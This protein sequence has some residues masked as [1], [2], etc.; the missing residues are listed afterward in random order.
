MIGRGYIRHSTWQD[1]IAQT[2]SWVL[3]YIYCPVFL[4]F[5]NFLVLYAE[6]I[7]KNFP[8]TMAG[9]LHKYTKP[10]DFQ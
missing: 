6:A 8:L 9:D 10:V 7:A 5:G 2:V 3:V 1:V 4:R